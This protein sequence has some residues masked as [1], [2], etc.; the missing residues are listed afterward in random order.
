MS[1]ETVDVKVKKVR[2]SGKRERKRRQTG[3]ISD[4][5]TRDALTVF[6]NWLTYD[7][8]MYYKC[9]NYGIYN[10]GETGRHGNS[11]RHVYWERTC[12]WVSADEMQIRHSLYALRKI[13]VP[14]APH[15]REAVY[16]N[17][18]LA[19]LGMHE[20]KC[21]WYYTAAT[22]NKC[23]ECGSVYSPQ[24]AALL[25]TKMMPMLCSELLQMHLV[26]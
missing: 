8:S 9:I 2:R 23:A 22:H 1:T 25:K 21:K 11:E 26:E 17:K 4:S 12:A 7:A 20:R 5:L 16:G 3:I 13:G 6:A 14:C 10:A 24:R 18:V 15:K 19:P